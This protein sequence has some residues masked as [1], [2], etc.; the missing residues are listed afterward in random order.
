MGILLLINWEKAFQKL[1]GISG[2]FYF[3]F[4]MIYFIAIG[5]QIG[6]GIQY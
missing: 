2:N 5:I 3:A 6:N 1:A 4:L